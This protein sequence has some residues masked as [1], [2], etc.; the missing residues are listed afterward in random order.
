MFRGS[1]LRVDVERWED[2]E[3][4]REV[5]RHPGA[6]AV[7][8]ITPA[9]DVVLVRQFRE[10][11][12]EELLELPAGIRDVA[13]E[14]PA[15]TARRELEEE[16]GYRAGAVVP[17]GRVHT[18]PG[19]ADE[20]IELYAADAEPSE[21]PPERGIRT[22]TMRFG[23]AVAAVRDGRITDAKT[24]AGILLAGSSRGA[25]AILEGRR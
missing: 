25:R 19:F 8:A 18:S 5:V 3:R 1:L 12:R 2:P 13:G 16:T 21:H 11:V 23:E 6:V 10:P 9:G 7:V 4:E 14:P 22:E 20:A 24:V 17:L 15:D